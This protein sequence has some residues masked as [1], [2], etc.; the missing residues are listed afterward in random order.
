V[1]EFARSGAHAVAAPAGLARPK[2]PSSPSLDQ[3][4]VLLSSA[5]K[6]LSDPSSPPPQVFRAAG[7]CVWLRWFVA[8]T[9]P[10]CP[11]FGRT[12]SSLGRRYR[13]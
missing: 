6:A 7:C 1:D 12:R 8:A 9:A 2:E 4:A 10:C 11:S 5:E 13:C 3:L